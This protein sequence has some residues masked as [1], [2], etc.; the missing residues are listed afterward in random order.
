MPEI[1][2]ENDLLRLRVL[3]ALGAGVAEFSLRSPA[4]GWQPVWRRTG[5]SP[6]WFNDLACYLLA[7]WSNRIAGAAFMLDGREVR[8][9]PDWPDGAAIHG[10]VKD[11]AWTILDRSPASARLAFQSA[12]HA[13]LNWP[14]PFE[15]ETRYEL[16]DQSLE[17]ELAVINRAEAAMP[18]GL[19]FHP[20]YMRKLWD[21]RDDVTVRAHLSGRYPAARMIPTG[22]ARADEVTAHLAAGRPLAPLDLDDVFAG[23]DPQTTIT[24]PASGVRASISASPNLGHTVIYS[25]PAEPFFCLEPVSMVNNGF[26]APGPG[27]GVRML[28]PGESMTGLMTVRLDLL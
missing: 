14:W 6:A 2:I 5:P 12:R 26:N 7:P 27:S 19:G 11:R 22:P 18:A 8:L 24:W 28:R 16:H 15:A 21:D 25:P 23:F 1:L 13:D 9:R 4:G 10:V 20:F 3:P 17:V